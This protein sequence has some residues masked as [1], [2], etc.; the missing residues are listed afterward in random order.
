MSPCLAATGV[1][2]P[3]G[4][5][6][7]GVVAVL[8]GATLALVGRR[9]AKGTAGAGVLAVLLLGAVLAAGVPAAPAHAA[10]PTSECGQAD[11]APA[12]ST[13]APAQAPA[14]AP[15]PPAPGATPPPASCQ[16][17]QVTDTVNAWTGSRSEIGTT[18]NSSELTDP[19]L[20]A[21][22]QPGGYEGHLT[23][24]SAD[25]ATTFFDGTV[26]LLVYTLPYSGADPG[27][28]ILIRP[29]QPGW[30]LGPSQPEWPSPGAASSIALSL[31]L[32]GASASCPLQ[33]SIV[34]PAVFEPPQPTPPPPS[35]P[36]T[37]PPAPSPG[38][39]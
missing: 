17:G 10:S 14:V 1:N 30:I 38:P 8:L 18:L 2:T 20:L 25:G 9:R 36:P 31:A 3:V 5:I 26:Q 6:A 15:T 29:G 35:T 16:P 33:A 24:R 34:G 22:L 11:P 32:A 37:D 12:A 7:L 28:Q 19:T 4:W 23:W 39:S 21:A 27:Q 13:S